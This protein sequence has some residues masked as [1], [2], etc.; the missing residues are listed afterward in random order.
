[1]AVSQGAT[2]QASSRNEPLLVLGTTEF[3][4]TVA[5]SATEA[6]YR[7]AG[8]VENLDRARC[9]DTLLGLP[10]HWI[11]DVEAL[12]ATHVGVCAIG[13]TL[14]SGFVKVAEGLGLRFATVIHPTAYV[15][16]TTS[17]GEGTYVGP[18]ATVSGHTRIG[19]HVLVL[20]GVVIGHHVELGDFASIFMG[21]RVAGS[22]T[23]GEATCVATGAVVIDH[24]TVGSHSIVGAGAVVV[25]DVPDNVQV[26]G[27]P[28]RVVREGITGR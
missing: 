23:I 20:A 18:H 13:T 8:F 5:G 25:E 19:R 11:E 12:A 22:T 14:R 6:G 15:A 2:R 24:I 16:D 21:A 4:A 28:A 1:M 27:V 17:L 9:E 3:S 7:V 26:I 10:V